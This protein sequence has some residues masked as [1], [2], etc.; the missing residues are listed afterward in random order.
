MMT[1]LIAQFAL[2]VFATLGFTIIFRV[3][4]R[5]IPACIAIG[6]IGWIT[7]LISIQYFLSPVFGCFIGA[8]VVGLCSTFAAH[9]LK[10]ATTIFII[11]GILCLVPGAK[12]FYTM[13]EL[14][15]NDISAAAE[16]GLSTLLMA[17][18]IA[19]GLLV[20]GAIINTI[21]AIVRKTVT[22]KDKI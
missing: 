11:P 3:P 5:D 4:V 2:A 9:L 7:Y 6:G 17:G 18:A 14:L 21:R 1:S 19:M 15:S 20:M 12:I 22:I 16:T 10:D 8:C 13:R